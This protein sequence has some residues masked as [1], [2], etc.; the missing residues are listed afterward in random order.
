MSIAPGEQ[1]SVRMT[2]DPSR[3]NAW[4]ALELSVRVASND[5]LAAPTP[6]RLRA[7][8][9]GPFRH[10]QSLQHW[11]SDEPGQPVW[12]L[13]LRMG[14]PACVQGRPEVLSAYTDLD[15]FDVRVRPAGSGEWDEGWDVTVH[16]PQLGHGERLRGT[17]IL[18]TNQ[19]QAREIRLRFEASVASSLG[20]SG[21]LG[22]RRTRAA[23]GRAP[24]PINPL[25]GAVGAE[26][27]AGPSHDAE[28]VRKL[29]PGEHAWGAPH[30]YL[31]DQ[32][33]GWLRLADRGERQAWIRRDQLARVEEAAEGPESKTLERLPDRAELRLWRKDGEPLRIL[34]WEWLEGD[35]SVE[36]EVAG[37]ADGASQ[38]LVGRVSDW[39]TER[40]GSR[41]AI[42]TDS[43]DEPRLVVPVVVTP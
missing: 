24:T 14:D 21:F 10:A 1:D 16:G 35:L 33:E 20:R 37:A 31:A 13:P 42:E 38:R 22:F 34:R 29:R 40:M 11:R 12:T 15:G 32:V 3:R 27:R 36:F 2:L 28:L 18:V 4:G 25:A 30:R 5:P 9:V 6:I 8:V 17:L 43:E 7:Q 41:L 23:R 19:A 39:P 26:L